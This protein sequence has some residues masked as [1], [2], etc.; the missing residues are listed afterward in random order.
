MRPDGEGGGERGPK[1]R[2]PLI[3]Q[4][5]DSDL[6]AARAASSAIRIGMRT[7]APVPI[8][9]DALQALERV[10]EA[11]ELAA[12]SQWPGPADG[13]GSENFRLT[14]AECFA[15]MEALPAPADP[16]Q[17]AIHAMSAMAYAHMGEGEESAGRYARESAPPPPRDTGG[18][19]GGWELRLLLGI[20]EAVLLAV[21]GDRAGGP[22]RGAGVIAGLRREQA[23]REAPYFESHE[24]E[25]RVSAAHR[26]ASLYHLAKCAELLCERMARKRPPADAA[27]QL[28]DQFDMALQHCDSPGSSDLYVLIQTVR[29][30]FA[31][32]AGAGE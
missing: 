32:M 25:C 18:G 5:P 9:A 2:H 7:G 11:Y 15:L 21:R 23:Q 31:G 20:Y 29:P 28:S 8:G 12:I 13:A 26:I 3:D 22:A 16:A 19:P 1:A 24:P 17:M 30:M 14:C 10:A 4:L 6:S 27:A